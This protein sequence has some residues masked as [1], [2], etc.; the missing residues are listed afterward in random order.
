M[1][2]AG[3]PALTGLDGLPKLCTEAGRESTNA[4]NALDRKR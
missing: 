2:E 4:R 3:G 1:V